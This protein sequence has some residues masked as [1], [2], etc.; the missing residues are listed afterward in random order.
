MPNR[1]AVVAVAVE[2]RDD[3][4]E[5]LGHLRIGSALAPFYWASR[6]RPVGRSLIHDTLVRPVLAK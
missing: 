1:N 4:I 6:I 2:E 3:G 5:Q